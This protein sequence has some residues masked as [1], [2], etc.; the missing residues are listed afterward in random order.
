MK[1]LGSIFTYLPIDLTLTSHRMGDAAALGDDPS[2]VMLEKQDED[3]LH[4]I[5]AYVDA[6]SA[7]LRDVSLEIHDHPELQY[8]EFH[9]HDTLTRYMERR[10]GWRV[11][12]SAYG[13]DTAFVS[14]SERLES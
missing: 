1:I 9:A 6:L 2:F 11:V 3:F 4:H 13:I 12:R 14:Y 7:E 8:K 5:S 10:T